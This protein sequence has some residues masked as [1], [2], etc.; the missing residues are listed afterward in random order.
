MISWISLVLHGF[1]ELIRNY[2]SRCI[3]KWD[4]LK[5]IISH[6]KVLKL[7]THSLK[8]HKDSIVAIKISPQHIIIDNLLIFINTSY[9][10]NEGSFFIIYIFGTLNR[11]RKKISVQFWTFFKS[12]VYVHFWKPNIG[13]KNRK[14]LFYVLGY[15]KVLLIIWKNVIQYIVNNNKYFND[16][17]KIIFHLRLVPA[18]DVHVFYARSHLSAH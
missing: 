9:W 16:E 13:E 3:E 12:L 8:T 18:Q 17:Q 7:Y 6:V 1:K 4:T 15:S 2:G 10:C 14:V 5:W 11:L